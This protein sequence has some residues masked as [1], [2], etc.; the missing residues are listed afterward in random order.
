MTDAVLLDRLARIPLFANF[1]A[2]HLAELLERASLVDADAGQ[3]IIRQGDEGDSL[4]VVLEGTLRVSSDDEQHRRVELRTLASSDWFGDIALLDAGPR[5]ASVDSLT[6]CRLLRIDRDVFLELLLHHKDLLS[7]VLAHLTAT[8]RGNTQRILTEEAQRE[9][10]RTQME[11]ERYRGLA[12]MVAGVAHE[13]NTPLGTANTAASILK[14]RA[15][16]DALVAL[17]ADPKLRDTLDDLR[18][19]ADLVAANIARAHTLIQRFKT[20]SVSETVDVVEWLD[21]PAVVADIIALF[22]INARQ[23]HLDI[24][25]LNELDGESARWF[26][27]RG[28][29]TQVVLNLL[30]NIERYAYPGG[31]GGVVEIRLG[32]LV[33]QSDRIVLEVRDFGLGMNAET[34]ARVYDPFFTTGRSSGGSGLGLA[35]VHNIVTSVLDGTIAI[36]SAPGRGTTVRVLLPKR[37]TPATPGN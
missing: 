36:D 23:A 4:Y 8:V 27:Y 26:G 31:S 16:S 25:L 34:L 12:H 14:S 7:S 6:T 3:S 10:L 15:A 28:Y 29:L 13:L 5:S 37:L 2:G 20:L 18:T 21:L 1:S 35:I 11:L 32:N 30:T 19:A 24:R 33:I 22:S 9:A 17:S